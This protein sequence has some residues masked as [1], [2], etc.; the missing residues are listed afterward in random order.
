MLKEKMVALVGAITFII[1]WAA[2]WIC[3]IG[4]VVHFVTKYW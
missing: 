3:L 4:V 1:L 2:F